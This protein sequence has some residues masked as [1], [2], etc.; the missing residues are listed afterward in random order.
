LQKVGINIKDTSGQLKDMDIILEEMAA[1]WETLGKAERTAL[2][3]SV[4]GVRQYTQLI[5]LMDNWDFMESNLGVANSAEGT[6]QEQ[7]DIYAESWEG[8]RDRV[9]AAAEA[10]Y[11]DLLND[12]FFIDLTNGLEKVLTLF[13]HFLDAIGGAKGLI[14]GLSSILLNT[15][16]A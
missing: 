15:F 6:L 5:A 9:K 7:A 11:S 14:F 12:D 3:Q 8:A 16:S 13:D 10:I 2:A 1:K 4:A